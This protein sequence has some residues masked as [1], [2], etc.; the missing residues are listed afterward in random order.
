[1]I[2]EFPKASDGWYL[3][4][5]KSAPYGY[6]EILN[7][8]FIFTFSC[9]RYGMAPNG[10]LGQTKHPKP[11]GC[12]GGSPFLKKGNTRKCME[13]LSVCVSST[14]C[15]YRTAKKKWF[16]LVVRG[17]FE[18]EKLRKLSG[19]TENRFWEM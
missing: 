10:K 2:I 11:S 6:H 4:F 13:I 7:I 8:G 15:V 1:M 17:T 5:S 14:I 12:F 9:S 16:K 3:I 19:P 18:T